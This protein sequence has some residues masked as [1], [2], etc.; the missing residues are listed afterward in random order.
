MLNYKRI[1]FILVNVNF[2]EIKINFMMLDFYK[3]NLNF[4]VRYT[5]NIQKI[6]SFKG[7]STL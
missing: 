4:Q 6:N 5:G 7:F 1:F 3:R 2:K